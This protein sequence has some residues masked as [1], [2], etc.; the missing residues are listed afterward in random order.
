MIREKV[1]SKN[2]RV[3]LGRGA[4]QSLHAKKGVWRTTWEGWQGSA[5]V[6][7]HV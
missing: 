7:G 5:G 3:L 2:Y 4:D 6:W 1:G